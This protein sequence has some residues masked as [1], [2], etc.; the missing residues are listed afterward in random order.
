MDSTTA[1]EYGTWEDI[2]N[3]IQANGYLPH[4]YKR[5]IIQYMRNFFEAYPAPGNPV[6]TAQA[7]DD[8]GDKLCPDDDLGR[9]FVAY[10][11]S[12]AD[13][14]VDVYDN[15]LTA[16]QEEQLQSYAEMIGLEWDDEDRS[17]REYLNGFGALGVFERCG[18][19][20][21][22]L[23]SEGLVMYFNWPQRSVKTGEL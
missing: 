8:L 13:Y 23:D 12:H 16:A 20:L 17:H 19:S 6:R 7:V 15:E 1:L 10:P 14:T 21:D 4:G 9:Y 22:D 5:D 11:R 2:R 18:T 3:Y